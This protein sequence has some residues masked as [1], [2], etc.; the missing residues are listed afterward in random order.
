MTKLKI[1]NYDSYDL[2]EN[3]GISSERSDELIKVINET[4]SQ[5]FIETGGSTNP[6]PTILEKL[7]ETE[8]ITLEEY[9]YCVLQLGR[10]LQ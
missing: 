5:L 4:I 8:G 6:F 9:T 2:E 7:S 10:G 1:V 3:L